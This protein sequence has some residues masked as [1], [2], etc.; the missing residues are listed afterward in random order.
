MNKYSGGY[1]NLNPNF[2]ISDLKFKDI[3]S[4]TVAKLQIAKNILFRGCPTLFSPLLAKNFLVNQTSCFNY[5]F[6]FK[7]TFEHII[8]GGTNS[9]PALKFHR[10]LLKLQLYFLPECKR[11][12]IIDESSIS[13]DSTVDFY[14]PL[15]STVIEIDGKQHENIDEKSIDESR[16]E[17][18]KKH[19]I[20]VVRI[21]VDDKYDDSLETTISNLLNSIE[22]TKQKLSEEGVLFV[23]K[24]TIDGQ[25]EILA[26]IFRMQIVLLDLMISGQILLKKDDVTIEIVTDSNITEENLDLCYNDLKCLLNNLFILNDETIEFPIIHF[27]I[28][29]EF[30]KKESF[31]VFLNIYELYDERI[32]SNSDIIYVF[33]DYFL[34]AEKN[35]FDSIDYFG[36][37]KNYYTVLH[38]NFRFN[39][40][41][42]NK[43][44]HQNA[45]LYFLKY[46]FRYEE[47]RP[48][49]LK[50]ISKGLNSKN[51][52][53]GILPTGSGKSICYQLISMLT[54]GITI[55][56]SPLK[57][58]ME[59]QCKDLDS[60]QIHWG[61]YINNSQVN[62]KGK[63]RQ[64]DKVQRLFEKKKTKL[65]YLS[66]ERFF[67]PK[68]INSLKMQSNYICQI[69]IDEVHCVSEWGH[70]FRTSYLLLFEFLKKL[71]F[72]KSLLLI[73][74]TAT[75]SPR[76][77][78]DIFV[79][80]KKIKNNVELI[81]TSSVKRK[82]LVFEVIKVK[83][84]EEKQK[85][86]LEI[87]KSDYEENNKSLIFEAYKSSVKK[88]FEM[89]KNYESEYKIAAYTGGDS[90]ISENYE[91]DETIKDKSVI[92]EEFKNGDLEFVIATKAFGMGVNI[93]DIRRTIHYQFSSSVE[94][95]YQE[96]G[97]AGRDGKMAHCTIIYNTNNEN[98][99]TELFD[100]EIKSIREI[101]SEI[102]KYGALNEQLFLI[103]NS[104]I[105][106]K[107]ECEFIM[108][109]LDFL[110]SREKDGNDKIRFKLQEDGLFE[111]LENNKVFYEEVEN[112]EKKKIGI[113]MLNCK[114]KQHD[115]EYKI[116]WRSFQTFVEKS[117]Y[118]LYLLDLI[119]LW[120]VNYRTS[121]MNPTYFNLNVKCKRPINKDREMLERV[122]K[123]LERYIKKYDMDF[124]LIEH[125][126]LSDYILELCEWSRNH[127]FISRWNSLKTMHE[128][129][130]NFTNSD[131]FANR[132]DNYFI[133]SELLNKSV[134]EPKKYS[135]W[136]DIINSESI[137]V[138]KDKL[139]RILEDEGNDNLA[140][141]YISAIV[142]L[143]LNEFNCY[144]G[145]TRFLLSLNQIE[146]LDDQSIINIHK[147]TLQLLTEEEQKRY[148]IAL[149]NC[150]TSN[151]FNNIERLLIEKNVSK[152]LD[153]Y[154]RLR[155]LN[156]AL[157]KA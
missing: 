153:L 119:D 30:S 18:F 132:I 115:N 27:S 85:K 130:I 154:R 82:E 83:N 5:C 70:D 75:S 12:E 140:V 49:Q 50:I 150:L 141:N 144:D 147:Q 116:D 34:F 122:R 40:V 128:F 145:E 152:E 103:K 124:E 64:K 139:F 111:Y 123:A 72:S 68:F 65:L 121:L 138:L 13:D 39:N 134:K 63:E 2:V 129:T 4:N 37:F 43:I 48:K 143:K 84:D 127:F 21:K 3:D 110:L 71:N 78:N 91:N 8:K 57:V 100:K 107:E 104:T 56:V 146:K 26:G 1:C 66:P 55:V 53:I 92:L 31:H 52:V 81:K 76:V 29:P 86:L 136:F 6:G 95:M 54:P 88:V 35:K 108:C 155:R 126:E 94:S 80:F 32:F 118:K 38:N 46:F 148:W 98:N 22:D 24:E 51:A 105:D 36:S 73:G 44:E 62:V 142:R 149:T 79:E 106:P 137:D 109:M 114:R 117:L 14:S 7:G 112:E 74:T 11:N 9:N 135:L 28:V 17:L 96:M 19:N 58:L 120:E 93:K 156:D 41:D 69:A 90:S 151:V 133:E 99:I 25:T 77:T 33:N 23:E 89:I 16:D 125:D 42:E 59:D 60:F 10:K 61:Y 101:S 45:L 97:R 102:G 87:I 113:A 15:L 67:N 131:D 47:F 20:Q 157:N